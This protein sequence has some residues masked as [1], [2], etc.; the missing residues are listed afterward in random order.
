MEYYYNLLLIK[1]SQI[2]FHLNYL[3]VDVML[4][5]LSPVLVILWGLFTGL[6]F[7]T[8]S[9]TGLLSGVPGFGAT[10]DDWLL[11]LVSLE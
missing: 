2:I 3:W 1:D 10:F 5:L 6:T 7:D 11:L 9:V 4:G 8:L